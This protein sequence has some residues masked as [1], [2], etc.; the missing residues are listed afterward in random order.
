MSSVKPTTATKYGNSLKSK[1]VN[2]LDAPVSG[3]TIGAPI[4]P[5]D[6]GASK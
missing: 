4:V 2:Y 5:P 1:N 3:G 6:T